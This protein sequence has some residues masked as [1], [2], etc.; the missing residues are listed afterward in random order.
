LPRV[1]HAVND[2]LFSAIVLWT[3]K[4]FAEDSQRGLYNFLKFVE[5]HRPIFSRDAFQHR[6]NLP[7]GDWRLE[8]AQ[9]VEYETVQADRDAISG[10]EPLKSIRLRRDKFH[11]HFDKHFCLDRKKIADEAPLKWSDLENAIELLKDNLNRYSAAYDGAVFHI[12]QLNINDLNYLL[13]KLHAA[14]SHA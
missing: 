6:R 1:F 5:H 7:D 14:K 11:A 9:D 13:D 4:L 12:D 10:F 2:A 8:R 3:D